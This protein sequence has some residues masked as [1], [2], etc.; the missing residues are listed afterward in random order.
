MRN[1]Y[2][3]TLFCQNCGI[4]VTEAHALGHQVIFM[5]LIQIPWNARR[6]WTE[7]QND[8]NTQAHFWDEMD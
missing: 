6:E 1:I 7:E 8:G 5:P 2:E 4:E 3:Q